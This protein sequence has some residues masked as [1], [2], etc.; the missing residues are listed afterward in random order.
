MNIH[1]YNYCC[2]ETI[3][4]SLFH[5]CCCCF[6]CHPASNPREV[7][8]CKMISLS[9]YIDLIFNKWT[10]QQQQQ[11]LCYCYCCCSPLNTTSS[12]T[13]IIITNYDCC[14]C[15]ITLQNSQS[16][17]EETTA[18]WLDSPS[19]LVVQI[20]KCKIV[21]LPSSSATRPPNHPILISLLLLLVCVFIPHY[22]PFC[23]T[24]SQPQGPKDQT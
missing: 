22:H 13:T 9:V 24:K 12:A 2:Q 23:A 3:F 6:C 4:L 17:T 7:N 15:S 11:Q 19:C 14:A 20:N 18:V 5:R 10:G 16:V 8:A 1:N 21:K